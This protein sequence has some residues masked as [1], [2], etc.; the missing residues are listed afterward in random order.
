ML[1]VL[2]AACSASACVN[3]AASFPEVCFCAPCNSAGTAAAR[4]FE[5]SA[6]LVSVALL[7]PV[8]LLELK[9][10]VKID[11]ASIDSP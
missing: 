7:I 3:P 9:R 10:V 5:T 4:M 2:S 11:E 8:M 6:L 1:D